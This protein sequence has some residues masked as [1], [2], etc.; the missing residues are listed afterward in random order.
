MDE[1]FA[2]ADV[3]SQRLYQMIT[4]TLLCGGLIAAVLM[5]LYFR[6]HVP[7]RPALTQELTQRSWNTLQIGILLGVLLL[8]YFLASFIGI[9]FYEEQIPL[10]QLIA[11]LVIYSIIGVII[12]L[13]NRRRGGSWEVSCGMGVRQMRKL[14][15]SPLLYLAFIPFL[16]LISKGYH[17]LLEYILGSEVEL[18]QVA[19]IVTQELSWLQMLYIAMAIL[20]APLYEELLFRGIIFP[21]MV[22]R[23]GLAGAT[24]LVSLFFAAL[25]FHLPSVVPLFLLSAVLCLAYWRTGSL[26]VSI[27]IHTIFNAVS[28]F[29]LNVVG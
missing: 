17:L 9:F 10:V 7:N 6:R 16:M 13:I 20:V 22:K 15:I 27:G 28:I 18:Q 2:N 25:H 29:A 11:T 8:L 1:L 24:L 3:E 5:G 4:W 12:T 14:A 19:E 26:W 23:T 21:Y